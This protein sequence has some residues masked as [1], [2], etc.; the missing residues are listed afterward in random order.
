MFLAYDTIF[1][2]I[3]II[4]LSY[5]FTTYSYL[6]LHYNQCV[7]EKSVVVLHQYCVVPNH[8]MASNCTFSIGQILTQVC[9]TRLSPT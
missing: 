6:A 3:I 4:T 5:H 2:I 9:V 7:T 1:F 8:L